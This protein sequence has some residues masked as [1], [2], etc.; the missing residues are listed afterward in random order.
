MKQSRLWAASL[1]TAL[2][3]VIAS[4]ASATPTDAVIAPAD[5]VTIEVLESNSDFVNRLS[6]WG[7]SVDLA[8]TDDD[9]GAVR[10]VSS[11][12]GREIKLQITPY[13]PTNT[14]QV[15]GPWRSG[16]GARNS[17]GQV[18]AR[19]T[20]VGD[21]SLVE[22]ED[23]DAADWAAADEPNF[24]DAVLHIYPSGPKPATCPAP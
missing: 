14:V 10:T 4:A 20:T 15:G 7:P 2:V 19:V 3:I 5:T 1:S 16:P 21:C 12:A 11:R 24:V 18:H 23:L 22:F 13:D 8:V 6:L 17:D 9:T